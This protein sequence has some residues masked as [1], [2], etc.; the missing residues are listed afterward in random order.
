MKN[1]NNNLVKFVFCIFTYGKDAYLVGQCVT[2]LR[3]I[4][5][6]RS[7]IFVFDDANEPLPYP[8]PNTQYKQTH[9]DRK[10]N[11]NG[12]EC[13][14]GELL[15]MLEA[16]KATNAHV[17]VKVDS[18]VL[19]NNLNWILEAD[20]MNSHVGFHIG[21]RNHISGCCYSLPCWSIVPLLR[22]IK[23]LPDDTTIGES[24]LITHLAHSIGLSHVGY[25]CNSKNSSLWRASSM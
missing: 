19:V 2:A 4:G 14:D 11:L 17:V 8:I 10:G 24:I 7:N 13:A 22:E 23:K 5:A 12:S 25:D 16:S 20:F 6:T 1:K 15:C 3:R 9:F 21:E 18:D